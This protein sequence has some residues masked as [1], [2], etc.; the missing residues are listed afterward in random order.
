MQLQIQYVIIS[1]RGTQKG[2]GKMFKWFRDCRTAEQ[3]KQ[4]Y[5]E[6]VRKFHPDNGGTGEEIKEINSEFKIWWER[7]KDIHETAEGETYT[8]HSET[9]ETAEDFIEIIA[10]LS[11]HSGIEI[12]MCGTWL[13]ITGN[14]Y[15][16]RKELA[17]YGCRWSK[18]KKKWYWTKVEFRHTNHTPTMAQIRL[19]YGSKRVNLRPQPC[20]E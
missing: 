20:L 16:I 17:S 14:T 2:D 18:G 8:A 7:Y 3:G 4:L 10:N 13:W 12:E 6:L 5:R 9:T 15:P 1:T 19:K 11:R